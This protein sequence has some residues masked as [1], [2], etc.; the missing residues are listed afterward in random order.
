MIYWKV[1]WFSLCLSLITFIFNKLYTHFIKFKCVEIN[2]HESYL[3]TRWTVSEYPFQDKF[4]FLQ[5]EDLFKYSLQKLLFTYF[6]FTNLKHIKGFEVGDHSIHSQLCR[7]ALWS[8]HPLRKS[9]NKQSPDNYQNSVKFFNVI[10]TMV[11]ENHILVRL[12]SNDM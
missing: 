1:F 6:C 10:F 8:Q 9:K 3:H 11:F 7:L 12:F 5:I 4:K 2:S